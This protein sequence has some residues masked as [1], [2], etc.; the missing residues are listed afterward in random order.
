MEVRENLRPKIFS[1]ASLA[2]RVSEVDS[3][4]F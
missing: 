2:L 1:Y 4:D 3:M